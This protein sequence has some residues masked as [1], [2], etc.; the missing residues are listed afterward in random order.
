MSISPITLGAVSASN[1][2][3]VLSKSVIELF[4][5]NLEKLNKTNKN[6]WTPLHYAAFEGYLEVAKML[7]KKMKS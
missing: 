1:S 4:A 5:N 7:L 2:T 6:K 3:S